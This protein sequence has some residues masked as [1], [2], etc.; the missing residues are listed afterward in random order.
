MEDTSL[1][2]LDLPVKQEVSRARAAIAIVLIG[3]TGAKLPF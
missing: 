1:A 2:F 3:F